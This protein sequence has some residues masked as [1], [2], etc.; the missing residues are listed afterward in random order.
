LIV[1]LVF[2]SRDFEL[3]RNFSFEES[4]VSFIPGYCVILAPMIYF[5]HRWN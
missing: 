2:V 5:R 3:G 4:T 1:I